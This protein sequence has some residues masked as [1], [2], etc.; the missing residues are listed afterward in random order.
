MHDIDGLEEERVVGEADNGWEELWPVL[1]RNNVKALLDTW[2][3][4]T[5]GQDHFPVLARL[6]QRVYTL[7]VNTAECDRGFSAQNRMKTGLCDQL[8]PD[9]LDD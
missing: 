7:P 6:A 8:S 4:A 5:A 1:Q 2:T 3:T 9:T